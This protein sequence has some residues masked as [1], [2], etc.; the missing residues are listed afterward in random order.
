[1]AI[2]VVLRSADDGTLRRL[3]AW[4][5]RHLASHQMPH[6]PCA[7][8]SAKRAR[9]MWRSASFDVVREWNT[10]EDVVAFVERRRGA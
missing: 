2:A 1:V 9:Q 7:G 6:V 4:T 5:Q 8:A 3:H 10:I